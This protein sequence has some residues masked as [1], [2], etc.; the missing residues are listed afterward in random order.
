MCVIGFLQLFIS[1]QIDWVQ[2]WV[3][4]C[5][6]FSEHL[7]SWSYEGMKV[8]NF[9]YWNSYEYFTKW[10]SD[11]FWLVSEMLIYTITENRS[12]V[13]ITNTF[14]APSNCKVQLDFNAFDSFGIFAMPSGACFHWLEI[15]YN[16]DL[17]RAGPRYSKY[18]VPCLLQSLKCSTY[19]LSVLLKLQQELQDNNIGK[20][21]WKNY[22]F[23]YW[24]PNCVFYF[25]KMC[26]HENFAASLWSQIIHCFL[27]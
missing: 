26:Q 18:S 10:R 15:K 7:N 11:F 16:S 8:M 17:S 13:F 23:L 19:A 27:W 9:G 6:V 2:I 1:N 14:Q 3:C 22:W 12:Y 25:V 24:S 5:Q 4:G 20:Q 21:H